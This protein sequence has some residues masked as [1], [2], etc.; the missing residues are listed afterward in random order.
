MGVRLGLG[1]GVFCWDTNILSELRQVL[2]L[3]F[4]NLYQKY[5][6]RIIDEAFFSTEFD[7]YLQAQI[8]LNIDSICQKFGWSKNAIKIELY[9]ENAEST[10]FMFEVREFPHEED[11]FK[12][13]PLLNPTHT[14]PLTVNP[15]MFKT[16]ILRKD[17]RYGNLLDAYLIENPQN[18]LK[19][20][21]SGIYP[22]SG[23]MAKT[24]TAEYVRS[25]IYYWTE[26]SSYYDYICK[27]LNI[28]DN[29]R[30]LLPS[31]EVC[32]LIGISDQFHPNVSSAVLFCIYTMYDFCGQADK[33][34][35][36]KW[37]TNLW[38]ALYTRLS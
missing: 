34:D 24:D 28:P 21:G 3:K 36:F 19:L 7:E 16:E 14:F 4:K 8:E 5:P 12:I 20:L 18:E 1:L 10:K 2:S 26:V 23:Y 31:T 27:E 35:V 29:S 9:R 25:K 38:P 33:F 11:S 6:S 37:H 32:N 22:D 30:K 15:V 13:K 17:S